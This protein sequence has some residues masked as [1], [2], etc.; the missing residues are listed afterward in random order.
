M[1]AGLGEG[2]AGGVGG[3]E[4]HEGRVWG[5]AWLGERGEA[6]WWWEGQAACMGQGKGTSAE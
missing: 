1:E 5:M 6:G 2:R 4:A 3:A